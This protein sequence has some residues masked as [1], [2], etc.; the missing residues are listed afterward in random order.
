VNRSSGRED[1]QHG[2]LLSRRRDPLLQLFPLQLLL[3]HR[4]LLL[5]RERLLRIHIHRIVPHKEEQQ[6]ACN[7][8][9]NHHSWVQALVHLLNDHIVLKHMQRST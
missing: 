5:W 9:Q 1:R 7:H 2:R 4:L 6:E 8:K 3:R